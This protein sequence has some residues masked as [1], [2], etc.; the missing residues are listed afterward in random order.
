[1]LKLDIHT[2]LTILFGVY[3]IFCIEFKCGFKYSFTKPHQNILNFK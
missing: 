3:K 2:V 1:M